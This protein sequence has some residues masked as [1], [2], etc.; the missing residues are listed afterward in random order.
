MAAM[1]FLCATFAL[2]LL[3]PAC[4]SKTTQAP[5]SGT[6]PGN[7]TITVSASSGSPPGDTKS[8]TITLSVP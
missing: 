1:L 6:P 3:L 2:L 7:Y 8:Q 4:S 5:V